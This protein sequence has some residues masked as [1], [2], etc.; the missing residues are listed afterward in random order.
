MHQN[1]D[2]KT[3]AELLVHSLKLYGH[4][5]IFGTTGAGEAEIQDAISK[6]GDI[7][8]I[9]ALHEFTAVSSAE[10]YSLAKNKT[11]IALVD[12]IVGTQN[13]IGALYSAYINMAPMLV[14][15]SRDI[16]GTHLLKD[17]TAH[18][19]SKHLQIVEPWVKWSNNSQTEKM[20]EEDLSKALFITQLEPKGISFITLRHD[21]MQR[22]YN[23]IKIRIK[24]FYYNYRVP[25]EKTIAIISNKILEAQHPEIFISHAGRNPEY[26]E[27]MVKFAEM[28]GIKVRERRYFMSFPLRHPLHLG[29][30]PRMKPPEL[31]NDDLA[32]LFEFGILPGNKL[33]ENVDVIDFSTDFVRRRDIYSGG[34]YGSSNLFN[35][36]DIICDLGPTLEVIMKHAKIQGSD[37]NL[38]KERRARIEDKHNKLMEE[39]KESANNDIKSGRITASSIG[40]IINS[41]WENGMTFINGSISLNTKINLQMDLP[42]PGS[43]FSNPSGHLGSP[44]GMAYGAFLAKNEENYLNGIRN[45]KPVIC[46]TG[47]GDAIFGNFT[48]A[49][50]SVKHYNLGVVYIILNNGSWA[51]EWPYFENTIERIVAEKHDHQFIDLDSPRISYSKMAEAFSISSYDV[52]TLEEFD[53]ALKNAINGARR[54]EPAVIDIIMDKFNP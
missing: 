54:G 3:L 49:L 47:D 42:E 50:W 8:W 13:S 15:S 32:L 21:L 25:D 31:G 2:I 44:V 18:Y 34:D 35:S 45:Y 28:F 41:N 46:I 14:F 30:S 4:N 24:N 19:S 16:A 48:S 12:R 10:G 27:T 23:G 39:I 33:N 51:V 5:F 26:V 20:L 11:G 22:R 37:M 36:M 38:I 53:S 1:S 6:E 9:Q 7:K 43:Y 17:P 52:R 40:H 29:F